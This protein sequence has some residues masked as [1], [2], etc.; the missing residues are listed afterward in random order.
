MGSKGFLRSEVP[1]CRPPAYPTSRGSVQERAE[2]Q[3]LPRGQKDLGCPLQIPGRVSGAQFAVVLF[4]CLWRQKQEPTAYWSIFF[5]VKQRLI[6]NCTLLK[7]TPQKSGLSPDGFFMLPRQPQFHRQ[8]PTPYSLSGSRSRSHLPNSKPRSPGFKVHCSALCWPDSELAA[9]LLIQAGAALA[10]KYQTSYLGK[11]PIYRELGNAY[12][13]VQFLR[14]LHE[15][16]GRLPL[17]LL[18]G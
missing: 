7:S 8:S 15:A 14:M 16:L 1:L 5:D 10:V 18:T 12:A 13:L 17:S 6:R 2:W 9:L 4:S 11:L 3:D